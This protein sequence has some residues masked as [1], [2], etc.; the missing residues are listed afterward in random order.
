MTGSTFERDVPAAAGSASPPGATTTPIPPAIVKLAI[1]KLVTLVLDADIVLLA[2]FGCCVVVSLP[3]VLGRLSSGYLQGHILYSVSET[4]KNHVSPPSINASTEK[5]PYMRSEDSHTF[6]VHAGPIH[7]QNSDRSSAIPHHIP[8]FSSV[9][10]PLSSPFV[11]RIAP[12]F[13]SGQALVLGIYST[14]LGYVSLKSNLFT[15]PV[16]NGFVA[17]SQIPFVFAFATKNN[18][19]GFLIGLGYEKV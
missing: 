12:R 4:R 17:M 11:H 6:R 1:E 8:S 16:R 13:S 19:F 18:P 5:D 7:R 9:T 3:R 15:D 14:V 2:L 10:H